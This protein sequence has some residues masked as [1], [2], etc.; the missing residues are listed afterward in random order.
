MK[1][2]C[3]ICG[4]VYDESKGLPEAG[5]PAGTKFEDLPADFKCP[6]CGAPKSL[7]EGENAPAETTEE[8]AADT[9]ELREMTAMEVSILC[10]NLA[11]G[12][13]KQYQAEQSE[14]FRRLAELFKASAEKPAD[15]DFGLILG[16]INADLAEGFAAAGRAAEAGGDRGAKRALTWSE[17]VTRIQKALL[18]RC[19]AE[20]EAVFEGTGVY[21]CTICGFIYVGDELP[22]I[23]PVCKVTN[24][25]FEKIKG[26]KR[27]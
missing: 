24:R 11:R 20:G 17:K 3:S 14:S 22:A 27:T 16:K 10:S 26:G 21:V 5:I 1:F 18:E 9:G 6:I 12:C 23:C 4:F 25:K 13:E 2:T 15:A 7:F 8:S 19:A